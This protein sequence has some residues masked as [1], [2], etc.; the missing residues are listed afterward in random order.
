MRQHGDR[1]RRDVIGA[2]Q[3]L[4]SDFL[5]H[6]ALSESTT[7][8][9]SAGMQSKMGRP[10]R[11]PEDRLLMRQMG[12]RL[13]WVREAYGMSQGQIAQ[14]VGIDQTAWSL[15]ENGKRSPDLYAALRLI[16]KLKISFGFLVEGSLEGVER[17]LAIRLAASH[18]EL[19][20]PLR[21][22]PRT[23]TAQA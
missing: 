23:D 17:E 5:S 9:Q 19:A 13:M 6:L 4:P 11:T 22:A 18:P 21:M 20:A 16:S 3:I 8:R 7:K 12:Q 1:L 2:K 14:A 10:K 15:Y